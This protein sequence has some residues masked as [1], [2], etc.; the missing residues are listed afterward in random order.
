M[1]LA[2][3]TISAHHGKIFGASNAC[4]LKVLNSSLAQEDRKQRCGG[5]GGERITGIHLSE[6]S[7]LRGVPISSVP[8][9]LHALHYYY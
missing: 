6:K 2:S 5:G 9:E 7:A 3:G 8:D 4:I 1:I